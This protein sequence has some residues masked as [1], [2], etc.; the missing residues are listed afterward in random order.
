MMMKKIPGYEDKYSITECGDVISHPKKKGFGISKEK[1]LKGTNQHGYLS[2]RLGRG[3]DNFYYIHRLV[4]MTFLEKIEGKNFVNHIDGNKLNNHFTNLEWCTNEENN[5]H[6]WKLGIAKKPLTSD[7][8]IKE[9]RELRKNGMPYKELIKIY[10]L[11]RY[12]ITN[13][14]HYKKRFKS[15]IG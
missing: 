14:V 5:K 10:G 11:S 7:K 6:A 12:T 13:I 9:I 2:L 15:V 1:I 3:K 8:I 4:A